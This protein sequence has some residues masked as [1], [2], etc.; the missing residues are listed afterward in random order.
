[1]LF[2]ARIVFEEKIRT[3]AIT[4]TVLAVSGSILLIRRP[5]PGAAKQTGWAIV[6]EPEPKIR[7]VRPLD[8]EKEARALIADRLAA[9]ERMWDG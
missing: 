6:E 2:L 8:S 5:K 3:I 4:G 7:V 1:M 9:Y